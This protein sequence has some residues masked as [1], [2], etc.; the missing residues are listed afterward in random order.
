MAFPPFTD[1]QDIFSI[2]LPVSMFATYVPPTW[3]PKPP[4]LLRMARTIYPHWR[5]RRLAR[6]GHRIIPT[7]N[8]S[9]IT[10]YL[11]I[12]IDQFPQ[13]DETDVSNESYICFRRREAK[14]IRKTRASQISYSDRL[15]RLQ[16]ELRAPAELAQDLVL[17]E[18]IRK[19][20]HAHAQRIWNGRYNLVELKRQFGASIGGPGDEE[21]LVDKERVPKKSRE[22]IK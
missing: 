15:V 10:T 3:T 12:S 13:F 22:V 1:Y 8:V 9:T 2:D 4:Q 11:L 7:L 17:R 5:E 20:V 18:R 19:D 6:E 21:L 16:N 14:A